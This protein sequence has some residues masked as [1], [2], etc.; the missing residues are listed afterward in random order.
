MPPCKPSAGHRNT[1]L[2]LATFTTTFP[3]RFGRGGAAAPGAVPA[4][5]PPPRGVDR[6]GWGPG[7]RPQPSSLLSAWPS[8]PES[9]S[10][11]PPSTSSSPSWLASLKA[12][13]SCRAAHMGRPVTTTRTPKDA[14]FAQRTMNPNVQPTDGLRGSGC[15]RAVEPPSLASL[16]LQGRRQSRQR[17][18]LA[19]NCKALMPSGL[20]G[21]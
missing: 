21:T 13:A 1:H 18:A 9:P 16:A 10:A 6:G 5:A 11:G 19:L 15:H 7:G 2:Q 14:H 4:K 17:H 3:L 20:G 8:S 12:S